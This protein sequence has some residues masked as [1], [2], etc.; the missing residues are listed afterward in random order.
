MYLHLSSTL[1]G[2]VLV[3]QLGHSYS[4]QIHIILRLRARREIRLALALA[5]VCR[6]NI[7]PFTLNAF[8]FITL[9]EEKQQTVLTGNARARLAHYYTS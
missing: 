6:L 3:A 7:L 1:T 8:K 9:P 4:V 5:K 2:W